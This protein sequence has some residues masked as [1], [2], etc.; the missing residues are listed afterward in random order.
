[1]LCI[2]LK[3][4]VICRGKKKGENHKDVDGKHIS[5]MNKKLQ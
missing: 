1:M 2:S 4:A 5:K 3:D